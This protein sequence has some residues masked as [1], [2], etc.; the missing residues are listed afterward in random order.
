MR[1]KKSSQKT[2]RR[3]GPR[4]RERCIVRGKR[5]AE[6]GIQQGITKNRKAWDIRVS[7]TFVHKIQG[8]CLLGRVNSIN[9]I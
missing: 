9:K 7:K 5:N 1:P 6:S 8:W 3:I 2:H 4:G